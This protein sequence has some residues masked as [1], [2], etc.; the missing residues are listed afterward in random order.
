M[1]T[2]ASISNGELT[3]GMQRA[4][5]RQPIQNAKEQ[6]P[7]KEKPRG[8]AYAALSRSTQR[9]GGRKSLAGGPG[10]LNTITAG[11]RQS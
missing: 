4:A 2:L 9:G 1:T 3:V 11:A 10:N 5:A 6:L 7:R 8:N